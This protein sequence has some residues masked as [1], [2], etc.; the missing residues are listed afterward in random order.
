MGIDFPRDPDLLDD[1]GSVQD[2][3]VPG[4]PN[5]LLEGAVDFHTHGD[6]R[7]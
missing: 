7:D 3:K 4:S 6:E 2:D 5:E 1:Q